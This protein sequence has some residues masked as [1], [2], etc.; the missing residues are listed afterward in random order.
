MSGAT[1]RPDTAGRP[2]ST[3]SSSK[4]MDHS[5][6]PQ[7][8]LK[9]SQIN[10]GAFKMLETKTGKT[11]AELKEMY[12]ASGAKNFG[13]FCSAIVVSKNLNLD[14][15]AVLAGIK[16]KSLGETLQDL[17]VPKGKADA[18]IKKAEAEAKASKKQ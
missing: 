8:P 7:Q 11:E 17:G 4:G 13:Q 15:S 12:A 3:G 18:E 6:T 16:D 5:S 2:D 10:G 9:D 14:T 1:G